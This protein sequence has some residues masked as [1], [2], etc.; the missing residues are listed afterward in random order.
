M[1]RGGG[2]QSDA[3]SARGRGWVNARDAEQ[4]GEL[5]Y[6]ARAMRRRGAAEAEPSSLAGS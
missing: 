1:R 3:R 2:R 4:A 6:K 5:F